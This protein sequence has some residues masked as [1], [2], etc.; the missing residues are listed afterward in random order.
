MGETDEPGYAQRKFMEDAQAHG[1]AVLMTVPTMGHVAADKKGDGDV[2]QTPDYLNVR[3]VKSLPKKPGK[4]T[5]PPDVH[6]G[7]VYEDEF[8]AWLEKTKS[9]KTP[10]FYILDN[11]P[12]LWGST[13]QRVWLKNPTSRPTSCAS[14]CVSVA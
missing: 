4:L 2:N 14:I 6:D 8:V 12:D 1:A 13:H 11:E 10:V 7:A 3:F 9:P 5:Y